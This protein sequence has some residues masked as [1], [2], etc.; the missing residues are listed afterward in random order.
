MK[1]SVS[2]AWFLVVILWFLLLF[3]STTAR[4][5]EAQDIQFLESREIAVSL[6]VGEASV[7]FEARVINSSMAPMDITLELA[8]LSNEEFAALPLDVVEGIPQ[9][10]EAVEPGQQHTFRVAFKRSTDLKGTYTGELVA[11]GSNG[12]IA[13]LP[14]KL[15]VVGAQEPAPVMLDAG[16]DPTYLEE[17]N[18]QAF[19]FVPSP[20]ASWGVSS[21]EQVQID[22]SQ[23]FDDSQSIVGQIASDY[24]PVGVARYDGKQIVIEDLR[25]AGKYSGKVDWL[26][27]EDG[28]EMKLNVLVRDFPLYALLALFGGLMLANWL[29]YMIKVE[30]PQRR[31]KK[32]LDDLK[33]TALDIQNKFVKNLPKDWP[34]GWGCF[35]IHTSSAQSRN[36]PGQEPQSLSLLDSEAITI[37]KKFREAEGDEE[38]KKW[39]PDG[40]EISRLE[41]YIEKLTGTYK[42][43]IAIHESYQILKREIPDIDK[44][45]LGQ[46][47]S[48]AMTVKEV[49]EE[50]NEFTDAQDKLT[51]AGR[52]VEK[53]FV[54]YFWLKDLEGVAGGEDKQTV[55]N[56]QQTLKTAAVA[57]IGVLDG[58]AEKAEELTSTIKAGYGPQSQPVSLFKKD[59]FGLYPQLPLLSRPYDAQDIPDEKPEET[60]SKLNDLEWRYRLVSGLVVLGTG[61]YTVYLSNPTFGSLYDYL[62]I[63]LWGTAVTTGFQIAR[64]VFPSLTT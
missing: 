12:S 24:G 59:I 35:R 17:L 14:I 48:T 18:R 34:A 7:S 15:V 9:T 56:W 31:L 29:E 55:Q 6:P 19:N 39:A 16:V 23:S 25:R 2:L 45:P 40:T 1:S 61:F 49:F 22:S 11:V 10:A 26:P 52:F 44:L 32:K 53:F 33:S 64:S 57:N 4:A 21:V 36:S 8:R 38:R 51:E 41:G 50:K 63:F 54:L 46:R 47:V 28:G 30:R 13:R 3:P 27:A 62:N 42:Q 37:Q 43:A 60:L 58:I 5:Q 20:L